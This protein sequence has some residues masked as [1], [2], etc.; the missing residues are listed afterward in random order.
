MMS[1]PKMSSLINTLHTDTQQYVENIHISWTDCQNMGADVW[2]SPRCLDQCELWEQDLMVQV[3][4][5]PKKHEEITPAGEVEA[6]IRMSGLHMK[7]QNI[8]YEN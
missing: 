6:E 7:G 2:F 3:Y 5:T 8:K 4:T 1:S